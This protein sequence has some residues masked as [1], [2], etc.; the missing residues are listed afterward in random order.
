KGQLVLSNSRSTVG[1]IFDITANTVTR[2]GGAPVTYSG[3]ANLQVTGS[4]GADNTF[5]VDGTAASVSTV[6][7]GGFRNNSFLITPHTQNLDAI[8][9]PLS[10]GGI[11]ISPN[12]VN[13]VAIHDEQ[14]P[15]AQTYTVTAQMWLTIPLATVL[16]RSG[17]API[18][19]ARGETPIDLWT[20][21]RGGTV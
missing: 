7:N 1:H 19:M 14:A 5:V 10:I 9:G 8:Q 6:L 21:K 2:D 12:F 3:L 18:T 11:I 4:N 13:Q 17:A 16:N 20:A 15:G